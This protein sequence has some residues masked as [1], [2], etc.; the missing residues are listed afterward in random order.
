MISPPLHKMPL[1]AT[2]CTLKGQ[3]QGEFVE[4]N[5]QT[6]ADVLASK[7]RHDLL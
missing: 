4:H 2:L 6:T 1:R 5:T 7:A 3:N